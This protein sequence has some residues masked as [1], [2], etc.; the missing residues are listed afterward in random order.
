VAPGGAA[1]P[2]AAALAEPSLITKPNGVLLSA[3]ERT[4][5][6]G[7]TNGLFRFRLDTQ[8]AI[9]G[10]SGERLPV[11]DEGV[12]GMTRDCAGNLYVATGNRVL[13]LDSAATRIGSLTVP[14]NPTNVEFGGASGQTLFITTLE[15]TVADVVSKPALYSADWR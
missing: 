6:L 3:D 4:L 10:A 12:D 7:G 11:T 9:V 14:H 2:I 8:G 15:T 5:Y 13:V 1:E